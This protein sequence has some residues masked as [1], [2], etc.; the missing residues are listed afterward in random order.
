MSTATE[1]HMSDKTVFSKSYVNPWD[2]K[3]EY[4]KGAYHLFSSIHFVL[5]LG[6]VCLFVFYLSLLYLEREL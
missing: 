1:Y 2:T 3:E 5:C 4:F 6:F